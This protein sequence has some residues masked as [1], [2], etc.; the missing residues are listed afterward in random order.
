MS[1]AF[2]FIQFMK[3]MGEIAQGASKP[4]VAPVWCRELVCARDPPRITQTHVECEEVPVVLN[5]PKMTS[6]DITLSQHSFFFGAN[7]IKAV[8]QM[9]PH[10]QDNTTFEVRYC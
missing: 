2:G 6:E 8:H 5:D 7:N 1:D 10:D 4:S 3:A 9:F